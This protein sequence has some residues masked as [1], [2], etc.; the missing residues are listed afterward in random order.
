MTQPGFRDAAWFRGRSPRSGLGLA[1]EGKQVLDGCN[2][3]QHGMGF[4]AG[5]VNP[6]GDPGHTKQEI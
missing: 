3:K 4:T 1:E 2:Y 6:P 5:C